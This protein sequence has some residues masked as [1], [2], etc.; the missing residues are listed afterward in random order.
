MFQSWIFAQAAG[1]NFMEPM[2]DPFGNER[3]VVQQY[4]EQR[5]RSWLGDSLSLYDNTKSKANERNSIIT[6]FAK[7]RQVYGSDF[8]VVDNLMTA[9]YDTDKD[10]DALRA[11]VR[12]AGDLLDFARE[13]NI[14]M[15]I[16]AHPRKGEDE[17]INDGVSGLSDI[18]NMATNV[19]QVKKTTEKE[20]AVHDCD[21][22]ITIAKNRVYGDTGAIRFNFDKPSRRLT[23]VNGSYIK[24]YGWENLC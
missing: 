9:R 8:F 21:S 6:R 22:L 20:R 3:M 11:Q 10:R 19:I 18:T 17:D 1:T 23:P 12:F 2:V 7:A 16:V 4:A 15:V 14:H 24:Q 13:Q 5:I